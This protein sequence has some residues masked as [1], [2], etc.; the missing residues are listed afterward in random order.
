LPRYGMWTVKPMAA[1]GEWPL[2]DEGCAGINLS[3][4][5]QRQQCERLDARS[6]THQ[7]SRGYIKPMSCE[8]LS[9]VHIDDDRCAV[10][11]RHRV[12]DCLLQ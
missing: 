2:A 3:C 7:S 12:C 5:E 11:S 4:I 9:R 6:R 1:N 10:P 8:N